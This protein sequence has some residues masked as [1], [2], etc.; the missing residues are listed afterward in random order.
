MKILYYYYFNRKRSDFR[1]EFFSEK[2]SHLNIV[3]TFSGEMSDTDISKEPPAATEAAAVAAADSQLIPDLPDDAALQCVARVSR[4]LYPSL[5]LVSKSWRSCIQSPALFTTRSLLQTTQTSL[6]L[7]LR[8]GSSFYWYT[9]LPNFS[10]NPQKSL[11]ALP[12]IPSQ[13][14]GPAVAVVG[15]KVYVMGGSVNE[16]PSNC[17][18]VFDCRFNR[19]EPG[20]RMR[21]G[22]EFSAAGVVSGKIYVIGGCIVDN[23]SRSVNW[24]EVYDPVTEAWSPVPSPIEVRDKWMHGSAVIGRSVY[25]MADRGGLVYDVEVGEWRN[26]TKR[27]DLGWRGRAVVVGEVLYCYDYLGKIKGYVVEVDAWKE[28]RGVEKGLPKFL[29]GATMV[30]YEEKL[31]VLWEAKDCGKEVEIMAAEIEV[32]KDKDGN[33]NGK[34]LWSDVILSVPKRSAIGHCLAAQF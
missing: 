11:V 10:R 24:A 31:C 19:W 7:N 17:T 4:S 6:F 22:R 28:L 16:V 12:P 25:A 21:V 5:S 26:V 2:R 33:L 30:N 1:I 14:I 29:C 18:W 34:I 3:Q 23:W 20:P 9:L 13:P 27:L 15:P 32:W 8:I